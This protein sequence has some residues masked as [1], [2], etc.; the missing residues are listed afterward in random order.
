MNQEGPLFLHSEYLVERQH[1]QLLERVM[2]R[3]KE[4]LVPS[5]SMASRL[6]RSVEKLIQMILCMMRVF[7]SSLYFPC[8]DWFPRRILWRLGRSA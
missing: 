3:A 5:D 6:G 1:S 2:V 8:S 7:V 4:K